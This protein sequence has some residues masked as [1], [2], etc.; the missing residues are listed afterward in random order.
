MCLQPNHRL[1]ELSEGTEQVESITIGAL[2]LS[3][4]IER[5]ESVTMEAAL[6]L[7]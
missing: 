6:A 5:V 2:E 4:G 1:L 3:E 7:T